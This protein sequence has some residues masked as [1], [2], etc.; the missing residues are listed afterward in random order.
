MHYGSL[1]GAYTLL[2]LVPDLQLGIFLTYNGAIQNDPYTMNAL[3]LT[4][5]LDTALG[6]PSWISDFERDACNFPNNAHFRFRAPAPPHPNVSDFARTRH[7]VH[8]Y[9]G[10]YEHPVLGKVKVRYDQR[11]LRLNYGLIDSD[12]LPQNTSLRHEVEDFVGIPQ[13]SGWVQMIDRFLVRFSSLDADHKTPLFRHVTVPLLNDGNDSMNDGVDSTF[14]RVHQ[15]H[16]HHMETSSFSAPSSSAKRLKC[17]TRWH[18][19]V[20]LLLLLLLLQ[21]PSS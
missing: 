3:I 14:T 18:P 10:V 15:G 4:H 5:L 17:P 20:P 19:F 21:M 11:R 1:P 6:L 2:A 7:Q 16:D 8:T 13:R 12:L 9:V